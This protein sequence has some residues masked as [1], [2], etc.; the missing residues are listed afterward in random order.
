MNES[1]YLSSYPPRVNIEISMRDSLSCRQE[2]AITKHSM[3]SLHFLFS[4]RSGFDIFQ[5]AAVEILGRF[6]IKWLAAAIGGYRSPAPFSFFRRSKDFSC[7]VGWSE[8][9][10]RFGLGPPVTHDSLQFTF[11]FFRRMYSR[12]KGRLTYFQT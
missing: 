1:L 7:H 3:I 9:A 5:S 2:L 8:R 4:F 11:Y 10:R 12:Q 6:V